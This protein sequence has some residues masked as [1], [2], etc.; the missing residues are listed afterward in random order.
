M[1]ESKSVSYNFSGLDSLHIKIKD[2]SGR[3]LH[4]ISVDINDTSKIADIFLLLEKFGVDIDT[5]YQEINL[6]KRKNKDNPK[7]EPYDW[8]S[9]P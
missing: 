6:R 7:K 8:W 5:L 4:K 9:N 2:I 3:V 1:N